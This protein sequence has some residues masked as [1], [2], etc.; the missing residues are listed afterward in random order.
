MRITKIPTSRYSSVGVVDGQVPHDLDYHQPSSIILH[1]RNREGRLPS[2]R[3]SVRHAS[4]ERYSPV[5]EFPVGTAI[6]SFAVSRTAPLL[7]FNTVRWSEGGDGFAGGTGMR[8]TGLVW[9]LATVRLWPDA[10]TWLRQPPT[11]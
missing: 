6:H 9:I 5:A 3:L 4:E 11:S 1:A 7:Y 10:V 8:S 2:F